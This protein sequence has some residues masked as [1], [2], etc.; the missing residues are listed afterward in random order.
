MESIDGING[1]LVW[2]YH[3]CP[4]QVWFIYH[5][6]T[7]E[8][9]N[10]FLILGKHIHE[11]FYKHRKKELLIDNTIKVDL[12]EEE[13]ILVEVKKSSRNLESALMQLAFYLYYFKTEKGITLSGKLLVPE[14][15][16]QIMLELN[17]Q[18]EEK[19]KETFRGIKEIISAPKPPPSRKIL[20]CKKCAYRDICWS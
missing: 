8:Q 6:I 13:G 2:Y 3:I 19:L 12:I 17:P 9:N 14:E 4:R 16:K 7:G 15:R 5:S 20:H 10:D 18:L 1:T 11:I